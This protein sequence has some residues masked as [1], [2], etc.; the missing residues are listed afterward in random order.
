MARLESTSTSKWG[1]HDYADDNSENG[2]FRR[3]LDEET[4]RLKEKLNEID[5]SL[6]SK[7]ADIE[8][9]ERTVSH[10]RVREE[11]LENQ[12][13]HKD[14]SVIRLAESELQSKLT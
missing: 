9:L 14:A 12:L 3:L 11:E 1:R 2:M 7:I 13:D 4:R 8:Q 5:N 6:K 10:Q